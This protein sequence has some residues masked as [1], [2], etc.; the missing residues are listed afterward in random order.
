MIEQIG[1]DQGLV[2]RQMLE[3]HASRR[4]GLSVQQVGMSQKIPALVHEETSN[5]RSG[6]LSCPVRTKA[7]RFPQG[8]VE[9]GEGEICSQDG[10]HVV[11]RAVLP[12][13]SAFI[14]RV[15]Y[16]DDVAGAGWVQGG[17]SDHNTAREFQ[18][19]SVPRPSQGIVPCGSNGRWVFDED[20]A[21]SGRIPPDYKLAQW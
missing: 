18:C 8:P 4:A 2:V 9:V 17:P 5:A 3:L 19:L 21:R 6:H 13:G 16:G 1:C 10:H 12:G 11:P 15:A 20:A 7:Q 14:D